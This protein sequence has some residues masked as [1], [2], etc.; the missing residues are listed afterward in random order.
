MNVVLKRMLRNS[1][2]PRLRLTAQMF[3]A[4]TGAVLLIVFILF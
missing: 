3:L 1:S 2:R 4:I